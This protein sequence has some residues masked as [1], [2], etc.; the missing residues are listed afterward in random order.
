MT[1]RSTNES[2]IQ[3]LTSYPLV[4]DSITTFKSNA[5]G[6]KSISLADQG[7]NQLIAPF[8]PYAQRPY[9][10]V[11]PYVEKADSIA[12]GGLSKVDSTF[13]IV[14]EDTQKLKGSV[15]ELAY[16]PLRVAGDSKDYVLSTYSNEYE[17][18][19][20]R[21]YIS[22]GRAL[23]TTGL[24]VTSESLSWLSSFLTQKSKQT[25]EVVK[26]KSNN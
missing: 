17:K 9:G 7:Y 18:C 2:L 22:G 5:Y 10:Y 8:I 3:H 25:K 4:S 23:I 14:K 21:G 1:S 26:E 13:P 6:K 11:K 20:G 16:F 12:D 19:G 24:V 15:L